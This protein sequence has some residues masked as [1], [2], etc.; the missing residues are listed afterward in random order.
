[1]QKFWIL[2]SIV[3]CLPLSLVAQSGGAMAAGSENGTRATVF[4]GY[5]YLRN[6]S[7]SF[8][9]WEGQ[10]TFPFNRYLGVTADVSG[11]SLTPFSFSALGA[12]AFTNQRLANYL[13]GPT[14]TAELG[15]SS[16]FAHALFGEAHSSLGAGV[17][18]PIIGGISTG[19]T[20]ANAFAMAFGGGID[21]GLTRHLAIRA[22]QVDY[23]RTQFNAI[24]ALTTGLSSSLG[25]RQNSF[26]YSTG[27]VFRF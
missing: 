14:V 25:N 27:I 11:A 20:S 9:G 21:I 4:G 3:L 12:S 24:D 19:L 2:M 5:S 22:V 7:N 17:S 16:V 8:N 6:G 13:F 10:G 1:M 18:V 26:R 23:I 15:R